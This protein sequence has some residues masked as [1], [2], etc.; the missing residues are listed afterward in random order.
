MFID[1]P[2][3]CMTFRMLSTN[4]MIVILVSYIAQNVS[5]DHKNMPKEVWPRR[6]FLPLRRK[7]TFKWA[8]NIGVPEAIFLE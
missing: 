6:I 3:K 5:L 1:T 4:I 2:L 7:S 8:I